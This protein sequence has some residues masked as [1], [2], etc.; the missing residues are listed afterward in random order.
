[1]KNNIMK[2]VYALPFCIPFPFILLATD[3]YLNDEASW[4]AAVVASVIAVLAFAWYDKKKVPEMLA[5]NSIGLLISLIITS[6][7]NNGFDE[8][9]FCPLSSISYV[10]V[11]ALTVLFV[12]FLAILIFKAFKKI[13]SKIKK[14]NKQ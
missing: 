13:K 11:L 9:W 6:V 3:Y 2:A 1:M 10:I 14:E 5:G 8:S 4:V 7:V 12:Q